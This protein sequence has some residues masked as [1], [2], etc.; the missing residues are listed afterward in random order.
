MALSNPGLTVNS[1]ADES[2]SIGR[3]DAMKTAG[4]L[5]SSGI[6][7]TAGCLGGDD[8]G[9]DD[10]DTGTGDAEGDVVSLHMAVTPSGYNP[11]RYEFA[12]LIADWWRDLGIDVEV[13]TWDWS[14][15]ADEAMVQHEFDAFPVT[16]VG[17]SE[18]IDPDEY[19][20][21]FL[22]GDNTDTPG[23][24]NFFG[25]DNE[26]Y[27]EYA[28]LQRETYDE[29]E[30]QEYVYRA[31]EIA[32]EEQPYIPITFEP[33]V[34]PWNNDNVASVEPM[35][36][37][38]LMG[39]FNMLEAEP[40]DGV[41][42]L[43]LGY[44]SD[45]DSM[46]P[47]RGEATHDV[48]TQ[49]L[50]YDTLVRIGPDGLPQPWMAEDYEAVDD[51]TIEVTLRDDLTF[52]NGEPVTVEDVQFSFEFMDEHSPVVSARTAPV[53]EVSIESDSEL[54]FHLDEPTA[55]F[56]ANGLAAVFII[57][58]DIWSEVEEEEDNPANWENPEVIGSGPFQFSEWDR[59]EQMILE[60][61][62]DHFHTPN[63]DRLVKVPGPDASTLVRA[64]E[65]DELDMIGWS[66]GPDSAMRLQDEVDHITVEVTDSF[67]PSIMS[68]NLRREPFDDK[69]FRQALAHAVNKDDIVEIVFAGDFA[70]RADT[71]IG[72]INEF[73]H[74]PD[75]P[76]FEFDP[77][78]ARNKLEEAGY[79]WDD[80]GN[81]IDP[82]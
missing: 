31:Q 2:G 57:P 3:R 41:S 46:N 26:E 30:R 22:H 21:T 50:V 55:P 66:I 61:N 52:H 5:A 74:N 15:V 70:I 32:M 40:Q 10:D 80:D 59:D 69:L 17:R 11:T 53:E 65:D 29:D 75:V 13:E 77:D 56:I 24:R 71:S 44:P 62:E 43:R 37:E 33:E 28:E 73:W 60:A 48:Q 58:E 42:D 72:P 78:E 23:G 16:L 38:G 25:F 19:L 14:R 20:Y 81:L 67:G 49:R 45:V 51:T 9:D 7:V 82:A 8:D 18:R 76:T 6:V 64:M 79:A 1:M 35:M 68:F 27:N 47:L 39:F 54:T 12:Q 36:G 63:F 4:A 34:H